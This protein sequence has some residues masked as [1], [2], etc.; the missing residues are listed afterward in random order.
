M[1]PG[2]MAN[3]GL[4]IGSF[5]L[6]IAGIYSVS[7]KRNNGNDKDK[8]PKKDDNGNNKDQRYVLQQ[9]CDA[10]YNNLESRLKR[11]EEKMDQILEKM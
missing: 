2:V 3:W 4:A 6:A 1:D 5:F 7:Q 8:N 9:V 10:R 11:I